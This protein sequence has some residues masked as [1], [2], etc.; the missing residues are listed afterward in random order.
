MPLRGVFSV[1]H[2]LFLVTEAILTGVILFN[3][4]TTLCKNHFD[5]NLV[6]IHSVVIQILSFSCF[7]VILVTT[8]GG[9]FGMPNCK[10]IKIAL[11]KKHSATSWINFNQGFWRYCHFHVYAIFS[12]GS[13]R[14][15]WIIDL[16]KLE[17]VSFRDHCDQI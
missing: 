12:N 14:P 13:W 2:L 16:H 5:T 6:K 8:D 3:F 4:E 1:S 9:H 10:K 17:T 15:S 7:N 11:H